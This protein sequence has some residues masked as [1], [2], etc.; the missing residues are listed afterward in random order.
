MTDDSKPR[1]GGTLDLSTGAPAPLPPP[2]PVPRM[3]A[4]PD[5]AIRAG[6]TLDLSVRPPGRS[7]PKPPSFTNGPVIRETVD[8]STKAPPPETPS[9][10]AP[11]SRPPRDTPK[12]SRQREA[13]ADSGRQREAGRQRDAPADSGRQ[14]G[15]APAS[16]AS[17][18]ADL[19]D[20]EV[21]AKLRG[22]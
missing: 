16:A 22:G 9:A 17:S 10:P 18:L 8:F 12:R 3:P 5:P 21:L 4:E 1:A 13:P 6:K 11:S 20:P 2:R 15:T 7:Q 14:R 19:L